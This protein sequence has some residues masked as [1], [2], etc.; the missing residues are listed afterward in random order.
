MQRETGPNLNVLLF[1]QEIALRMAQ[2]TLGLYGYVKCNRTERTYGSGLSDREPLLRGVRTA[3]LSRVT[4][5]WN[6]IFLKQVGVARG[7]RPWGRSPVVSLRRAAGLR[8]GAGCK[9]KLGA[10]DALAG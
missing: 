4:G 3:G 9:L 5:V 2:G 10:F 8:A 6:C 1:E 7:P